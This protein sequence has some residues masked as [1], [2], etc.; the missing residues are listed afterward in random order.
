MLSEDWRLEEAVAILRG[1]RRPSAGSDGCRN[2][3]RATEGEGNWSLRSGRHSSAA[4]E[5]TGWSAPEHSLRRPRPFP[6]LTERRS[7]DDEWETLGDC[8]RPS[9]TPFPQRGRAV[10]LTL[11]G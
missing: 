6:L 4:R 9:R 8:S 1:R 10:E 5:Q 11:V 2:L 7:L 3:W